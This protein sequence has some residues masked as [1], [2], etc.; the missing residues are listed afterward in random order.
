VS[1][2]AQG[3]WVVGSLAL[4]LLPV[5]YVRLPKR[6]YFWLRL[7]GIATVGDLA[8]FGEQDLLRIPCFSAE[9]LAVV[10]ETL[11]LNGASL[12]ESSLPR[13]VHPSWREGFAAWSTQALVGLACVLAGSQHAHLVSF[14]H[15][16]LHGYPERKERPS[17]WRQLRLATGFPVAVIRC[18]FQNTAQ[19]A[20]RPVDW[21]LTSRKAS[22]LAALIP[23]VAAIVLVI[24]RE[25]IYGIIVN[26]ENL[27]VAGALPY[28]AI[29]SLR[30]YRQ[31]SPRPPRRPRKNQRH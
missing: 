4:P 7:Y 18:R 30:R 27:S 6:T 28:L 20:W 3:K 21:L 11:E 5:S 2:T 15:A 19:L 10:K 13:A 31:I 26:A 8:G 29:K 16:D 17:A 23:L 24:S 14:M 1:S 12:R 25:G 9:S 22:T